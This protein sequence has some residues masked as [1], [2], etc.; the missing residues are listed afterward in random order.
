MSSVD[1]EA[2]KQRLLKV[3][4]AWMDSM[5][6]IDVSG[7]M[8]PVVDSTVMYPPNQYSQKGIDTIREVYR[9]YEG[10]EFESYT[11]NVER[12]EISSSGDLAYIMVRAS[13]SAFV[14]GALWA[15]DIKGVIVWKKINGDWKVMVDCWNQDP[16]E[17]NR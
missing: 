17:E 4:N 7:I 11:H 5:S 9:Q 2:E 8:I 1:L 14:D 13:H 16:K 12:V 6:R 3:Y 10:V 15:E